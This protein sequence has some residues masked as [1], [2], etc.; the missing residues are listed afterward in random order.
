MQD[1][2]T[3]YLTLISGGGGGGV[4]RENWW[5]VTTVQDCVSTFVSVKL[6]DIFNETLE[7]FPD[8]FLET[9][10]IIFLTGNW[11]I[12]SRVCA[13]KTGSILRQNLIFS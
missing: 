10:Q 8:M 1:I 3:T 11:D 13:V 12:S 6:L 7:Q 9:K 2:V 4:K 5:P